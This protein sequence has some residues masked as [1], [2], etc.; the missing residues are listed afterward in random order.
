MP[1]I[2]K[3]D[4]PSVQTIR[5]EIQDAI[6]NIEFRYGIKLTANRS[7]FSPKSGSITID[8]STIDDAGEIIDHDREFLMDNLAW[9]DLK[10]EHVG[11][12]IKIGNDT[13][14]MNG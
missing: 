10:P 5:A 8:V 2:T 3:F 1:K 13:F 14:K 11:A 6:R 7:K 9:L 12:I 4:K